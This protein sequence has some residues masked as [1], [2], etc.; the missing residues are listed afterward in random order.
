MAI[1]A[2]LPGVAVDIIANHDVLEQYQDL[3]EFDT[4]DTTTSYIE[5]VSDA[6][7]SI[8]FTITTSPWPKT[9][10]LAKIC[11]DGRLVQSIAMMEKDFHPDKTTYLVDGARSGGVDGCF[12]QKFRFSELSIGDYNINNQENFANI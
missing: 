3:E 1:T 6:S 8:R 9:S 2:S 12:L 7:F 4:Y 10:L 5:A 11:L